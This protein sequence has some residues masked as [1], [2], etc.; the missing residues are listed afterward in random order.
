M[1]RFLFGQALVSSKNGH[2]TQQPNN[3]E[4]QQQLSAWSLLV[5]ERNDHALMVLEKKLDDPKAKSVALLYGSS[6]CP[7]LHQKLV[8]MGF[9]P[10]SSTWRTAWSVQGIERAVGEGKSTTVLPTLA[11]FLIF[12]LAIGALDWVG[13]L[14]DVSKSLVDSEYAE[15]GLDAGLY[16]LRHV[17]LYL[18][19]SKFLVDW[20]NKGET[21]TS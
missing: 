3:K 15:A 13:M 10:T 4:S 17:L 18:G 11:A 20:T 14:G 12:Y 8:S 6:H 5:T 19:L 1:R 2:E 7:D 16:L 21:T 9:R